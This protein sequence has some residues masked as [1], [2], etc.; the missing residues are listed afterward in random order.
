MVT[1]L[2]LNDEYTK[3]EV[4]MTAC[5]RVIP[6]CTPYCNCYVIHRHAESL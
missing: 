2:A 3:F 6:H 1:H 4:D 5:D